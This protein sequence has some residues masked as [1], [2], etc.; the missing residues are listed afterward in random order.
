MHLSPARLWITLIALVA[1]L[2]SGVAPAAHSDSSSGTPGVPRVDHGQLDLGQA[3]GCAVV[4]AGQVRCWGQGSSGQLATG[5]GTNIGDGAGESTTQVDLSGHSALAVTAGSNHACAI[6]ETQAVVCWGENVFGQLGQGNT[7]A[8]GNQPGEKPVTVDLGPGQKVVAITAGTGH[9]CALTDAGA[10]RCW[11]SGMKG[12]LANG[13]ATNIG[14]EPG[15]PPVTVDLGAGRT[16]IA[17]SAGLND[18]CAILDTGALRC[19]GDNQFGQLAQGNT[20]DIGDSVGET[21]VPVDL[22]G[23]KATA[24]SVGGD[25][26][27]AALDDGQVRCWGRGANGRLGQGNDTDIGDTADETTVPIGLAGNAAIA[28]TVGFGTACAVL[29]DHQVRCWGRNSLGELGQGNFQSVGDEPGETSVPLNLGPGRTALAVVQGDGFACAARDDL[30]LSCWGTNT[31]G[32]L[33]RGNTDPYGNLPGQT[34]AAL[35]AIALGGQKFGRDADGDGKRD[36]VD[37]CPTVAGPLADGCAAP[38]ATPEAVLKGKKVVLD[39]VLA[40]K[41]ASAKCPAK[42]EVTVKT[43]SKA[44]RV[45]V[46]KQLKITTVATGCLVK[47]KVKLPAKPKKTAKVKVTVTGKKLVP[48]RLVAVRNP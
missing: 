36:V 35:P 45:K 13:L 43:K 19:W 2:L 9:T 20:T 3:F 18:T 16:A 24:V 15:E 6:L 25:H 44:G 23:H 48:K 7:D 10:V 27:C 31:T 1:A 22:G 46:T 47:G 32:Q 26:T 8:I 37:T 39:A 4:G 34:A 42:A 38:T 40:K 12:Q 28:V 30:T 33:G 41:Q 29:A 11:G 17:I 21:T 5:S 14:N